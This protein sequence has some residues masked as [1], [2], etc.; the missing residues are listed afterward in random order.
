MLC[1]GARNVQLEVFCALGVIE[2]PTDAAWEKAC[3]E[4]GL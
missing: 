1:R 4:R 3:K 2:A